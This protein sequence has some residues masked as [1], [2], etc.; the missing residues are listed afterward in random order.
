[1]A[2]S[3]RSEIAPVPLVRRGAEATAVRWDLRRS[4]SSPECGG[5]PHAFRC[6]LTTSPWMVA[7]NGPTEAPL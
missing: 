1:M 6:S 5:Q 3:E 7:S 4:V 2:P